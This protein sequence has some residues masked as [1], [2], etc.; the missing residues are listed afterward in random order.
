MAAEREALWGWDLDES[1]AE[2]SADQAD[3]GT[4]VDHDPITEPL[5]LAEPTTEGDGVDDWYDEREPTYTRAFTG[6]P[7][8]SSVGALTFKAAP[9]P[10]YRTKRGVIG[11]IAAAAAVLLSVA[12]LQLVRGSSTDADQPSAPAP[13]AEPTAENT[14][15]SPVGPEPSMSAPAP[16]PAPP[17]PPPPPPSP[18]D[19]APAYQPY[20]PAPRNPAPSQSNKPEIGV[21]RPP[22]SVAPDV[23][24]PRP[25]EGQPGDGRGSGRWF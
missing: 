1:P 18:Q 14:P 10:W 17:P 8:G 6:T 7:I 24:A 16:P 19:S 4:E 20:Y 11:V 3:T 22:M 9:A 25:G 5:P 21:T 12:V 15:P 2:P 23:R 13:S